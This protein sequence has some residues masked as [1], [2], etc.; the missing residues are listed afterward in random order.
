LEEEYVDL[1][2]KDEEELSENYATRNF[3]TYT[4]NQTY[5]RLE[6]HVALIRQKRNMYRI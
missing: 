4:P 3:M 2:D 6:R 5:M 1:R